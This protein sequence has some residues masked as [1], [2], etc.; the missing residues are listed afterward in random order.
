MLMRNLSR[1]LLVAAL[2]LVT[3]S[4]ACNQPE[5][6]KITGDNQQQDHPM[7]HEGIDSQVSE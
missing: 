1:L 2:A 3:W 7:D 5:P 6:Q 4:T